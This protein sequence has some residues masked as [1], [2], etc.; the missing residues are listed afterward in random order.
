MSTI[1]ALVLGL[2][3]PVIL[4]ACL[5]VWCYGVHVL[6][7]AWKTGQLNVRDHALPISLVLVAGADL[8]ENAFYGYARLS[9]DGY[10]RLT[11]LLS[12]VGPMK[13]LILLGLV[14][15]VSGY[16]KAVYGH[17]EL[18]KLLALAGGVW[19]LSFIVIALR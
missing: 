2:Y 17:S 8:L 6:W 18:G 11:G 1:D 4:F 16:R 9:P 13:T 15:A 5:A 19:F 12:A 10:N 7:P 14:F 3:P